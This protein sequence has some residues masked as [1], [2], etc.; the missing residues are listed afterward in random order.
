MT[1][2]ESTAAD[3]KPGG[4]ER[5]LL[6]LPP[7]WNPLIPPMG[8]TS[9]KGFLQSHGYGAHTVDANIEARFREVYDNYFNCLAH[10]IPRDKRGNFYNIGNDVLRN[11][12]LA[13]LHQG[14]EQAYVDLVKALVFQTFFYSVADRQVRELNGI[15]AEFYTRWRGYFLELLGRLKPTVLGLSFYSA[16]AAAGLFAF[17]LAKEYDPGIRT[18][19]GGA[20]FAGDLAPDSPNYSYFLENTPYIDKIL[21]GEGEMLFLKYLQQE[22][23]EAQRVYTLGDLGGEVLPL[24]SLAV[25]DFSD[26]DLQYYPVLAASSS[27]SC[28]FR[29]TFCAEK[30][31]WGTFRKKGARQVVAELVEAAKRYRGQMFVMTDSLLNP[32]I[33]SVAEQLIEAGV[34]IYWDGYLRADPSV[35]NRDAVFQ[36][37]RAGFYR[38]RLG[39]ESGSPRIL[40]AMGKR[41]DPGQIREALASLAAAGIKTTTYWLI[42][43]PGETEED[44]RQTLDLVEELKDDLYEADCNPFAY[45]LTGQVASAQWKESHR[46]TLLYPEGAGKMLMMQTWILEG[47]PAREE[48]FQRINRFVQHCKRLEIPNPYTLQE[49]F[50]ADARW[51]KL[52]R[53]AVPPLMEFIQ[54][55]NDRSEWIDEH[56]RVKQLVAGRNLVLD[57]GGW[58]F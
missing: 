6:V 42:G 52:H 58:G 41:I 10:Y 38:A 2:R 34:S 11:H 23:P 9:L 7:Y 27:R 56:K 51:E 57:D 35:C 39:L 1:K 37:R 26:L 33:D 20:I 5:I 44:F 4:D 31:L 22:L 50:A 43:Y 53:N 24:D 32:V 48:T 12:M 40:A 29:C 3:R 21:V 25:P 47:E 8:I 54:G 14:D 13:H 45:Y 55:K 19:M 30:V 18:V 46:S 17:K 16:T 49:I 28:P 36:W 15:M